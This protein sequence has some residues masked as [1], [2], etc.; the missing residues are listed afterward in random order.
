MDAFEYD[1]EGTA[2]GALT[3]QI[4]NI[5]SIAKAQCEA[6]D[7]QPDLEH[8]NLGNLMPRSINT[9]AFWY[10]NL[11]TIYARRIQRLVRPARFLWTQASVDRMRDTGVCVQHQ[12]HQIASHYRSKRCFALH[13]NDFTCAEDIRAGEIHIPRSA[14]L[15]DIMRAFEAYVEYAKTLRICEVIGARD[16]WLVVQYREFVS[17][18]HYEQSLRNVE[19]QIAECF[20]ASIH[21]QPMCVGCCPCVATLLFGQLCGVNDAK[22]QMPYPTR[23]ADSFPMADPRA[24]VAMISSERVRWNR[25]LDVQNALM[26]Y[27]AGCWGPMMTLFEV[28]TALREEGLPAQL[29]LVQD[30][31]IYSFLALRSTPQEARRLQQQ[32]VLP[33]LRR[34]QLYD[35]LEHKVITRKRDFTP[36]S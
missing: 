30:V 26:W 21:R 36:I 22:F 35:P 19:Q 28:A 7:A 11:H 10:N 12:A 33:A 20:A 31:A 1:P 24:G 2:L 29:A 34:R 9:L 4:P 32:H 25:L 14:E 13:T 3:R 17:V 23:E 8:I 6:L 18:D 5:V 15:A 16:G 27:F